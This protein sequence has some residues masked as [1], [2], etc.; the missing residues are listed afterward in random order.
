MSGKTY[1]QMALAEIAHSNT[2]FGDRA[3]EGAR[4]QALAETDEEQANEDGGMSLVMRF[5]L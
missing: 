4:R 3:I 1:R 5:T 2:F